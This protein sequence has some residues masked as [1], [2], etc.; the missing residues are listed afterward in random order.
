MPTVLSSI[1]MHEAI[2]GY[3]DVTDAFALVYEI[4][5]HSFYHLTFPT[6]NVTWVYD[7]LTDEWHQRSNSAGNESN[8]DAATNFYGKVLGLIYEDGDYVLGT[9]D[10]D[11]NVDGDN[12]ITRTR[13][14][15]HLR[16]DGRK[17]FMDQIE[18]YLDVSNIAMSETPAISMEYSKDGGHS[19]STAVERTIDT[20]PDNKERISWSRLGSARNWTFRFITNEK[21]VPH[22]IDGT[23]RGRVSLD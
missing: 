22:I 19:W 8:W 13:I 12:A 6:A 11:S 23:A 20:T 15:N 2:N 18:I 4:G 5:G 16:Q 3:S 17:I 21:Y 14:S 9:I 10:L 1:A 7:W